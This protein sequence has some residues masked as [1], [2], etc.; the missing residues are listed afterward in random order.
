MTQ[1]TEQFLNNLYTRTESILQKAV[2]EWQMMTPEKL[3]YKQFPAQWSAAQCLE[4]LNIYGRHYLPEITNAIL[5][6]KQKSSHS[7]GQFSSG[8]LGAYFIDIM[9]PKQDGSLKKRMKSPKDAV[10]SVAPDPVET[11]AEFI[12]QQETLLKLIDA[13]KQVQLDAVKV[14][15]SLSKMIRLRLG[16][17]LGFVVAHLERHELQIARTFQ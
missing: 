16:D 8:L 5:L 2:G 15:S 17:A 9:L 10:P 1:H 11:L 12:E 13:S 6:A 14:P 4:H 7:N 3:S